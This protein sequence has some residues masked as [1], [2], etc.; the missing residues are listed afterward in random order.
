MN[1]DGSINMTPRRIVGGG[2]QPFNLTELQ[3]ARLDA[4]R[5]EMFRWQDKMS[6]ALNKFSAI[7]AEAQ[8]ENNWPAVQCSLTDL[9]VTAV[10]VTVPLK[11]AD[12]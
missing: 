12:K 10:P 1:V 8:K 7:C 2:P 11:P 9:A 5:Q 4:A 6:D 3:K